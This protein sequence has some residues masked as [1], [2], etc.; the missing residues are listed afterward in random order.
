M[1]MGWGISKG[2]E[3]EF[4]RDWGMEERKDSQTLRNLRTSIWLSRYFPIFGHS[5]I[6]SWDQSTISSMAEEESQLKDFCFFCMLSLLKRDIML[7]RLMYLL[8]MFGL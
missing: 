8:M 2:K 5:S 1:L 6:G 7:L 4:G 3:G